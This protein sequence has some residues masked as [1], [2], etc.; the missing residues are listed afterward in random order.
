VGGVGTLGRTTGSSCGRA[1]AVSC[2]QAAPR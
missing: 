2:I 1:S